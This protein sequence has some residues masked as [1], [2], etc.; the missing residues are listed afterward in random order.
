MHEL[1]ITKNIVDIALEAAKERKV[2]EITIVLG[3]LSSVVE[4]SIRFC[5]GLVA[6]GTTAEGAV[7]AFVKVPAL[8]RCGNCSH[9]FGLDEGDWTCPA[10]GS[11]G[12]EIIHG[13]EFYIESIEVEEGNES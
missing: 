7:L 13:R 1:T 11:S 12:A 8:V 6:E 3:E 10:C 5:F 9:Q 4:D 2:K